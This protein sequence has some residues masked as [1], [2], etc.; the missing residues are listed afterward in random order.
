MPSSFYLPYRELVHRAAF[1]LKTCEPSC[2]V[3]KIPKECEPSVL[4]PPNLP[5][6][7]PFAPA[8]ELAKNKCGFFQEDKSHPYVKDLQAQTQKGLTVFETLRR[9]YSPALGYEA[10]RQDDRKQQHYERGFYNSYKSSSPSEVEPPGA[11][12]K[13]YGGFESGAS[14]IILSLKCL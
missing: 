2:T 11:Y 7:Q 8:L 4:A 10:P 6:L 14:S 5:A 1:S 3:Y 9:R 12:L 13:R